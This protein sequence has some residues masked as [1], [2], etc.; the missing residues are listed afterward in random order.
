MHEKLVALGRL[1]QIVEILRGPQGCP[2][3]RVQSLSSMS[4]YLL[5]ESSEVQDAVDDA[6]G[7]PSPAVA[8]ELGDTL[9]NILLAARIAEDSDGFSIAEVASGASDKLVRRHPHVFADTH[10]AGIDDVLTN[11]N[12]I[13]AREKQSQ[14]TG[15]ALEPAAAAI[16]FR[17]RLEGVPRSLP[18]LE[19]AFVLGKRAAKAGFDWPSPSGALDKVAEE[20]EEVRDLVAS[21]SPGMLETRRDEIEEELGDLLF[22]VV[23]AC[24]K[25]E[26][27]PEAALRS[28][29]RKF[30]ARFQAVEAKI[31]E[32][33]SA[34]LETMDAAW[35]AS[36]RDRGGPHRR[37]V[38]SEGTTP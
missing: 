4:R 20:L 7:K 35:E 10:V 26:V 34:S 9:I 24:R 11:W 21:T 1:Q 27:R 18:P 13:K 22:S 16:S 36:K 37:V 19:R 25:L 31:P 5:E 14:S 30:C 6:H 32:L 3:D 23:N 17:S 29:I 2:W 12:A 38:S 33:E 8:E 28:A 15:Q